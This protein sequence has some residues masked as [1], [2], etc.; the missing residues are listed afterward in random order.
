MTVLIS[1]STFAL[2]PMFSQYM[3]NML[4]INPAYAGNRAVNNV[5]LVYRNQWLG[6]EGNPVTMML[7][8]DKRKQESNAGYGAQVYND[9]LGIQSTTGVQGF[10]SYRLPFDNHSTLTMGLSGGVMNYNDHFSGMNLWDTGDAAAAD[11]TEWLPTAGVG[12][13]YFMDQWY[14]GISIPALL[15]TTPKSLLGNVKRY[16]NPFGTD[17]QYYLTG[18]YI[19]MITNDLVVKPSTLV[20]YSTSSGLQLDLNM[21]AWWDNKYGVGFSYRTGNAIVG[22]LECQITPQFRLGAA[23]DYIVSN[24]NYQNNGAVEVLLRYEFDTGKNIGIGS[25]RYY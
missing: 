18:G 14:V 16:N 6:Y 11:Q 22:M 9:H 4:N 25:P 20:K 19:L 8:W 1:T 23:Y 15:R 21:N 2:D 3:F 12:A 10:Y 17:Y 24:L 13:L 5:S 7:S